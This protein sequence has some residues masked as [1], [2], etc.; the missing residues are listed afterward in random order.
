MYTHK[1]RKK[2]RQLPKREEGKG[3]LFENSWNWFIFSFYSS[4]FCVSSSQSSFLL[5]PVPLFHSPWLGSIVILVCCYADTST[6]FAVAAFFSFPL[7]FRTIGRLFVSFYSKEKM[8]QE[9][10]Y[11][12]IF[13][14]HFLSNRRKVM[15]YLTFKYYNFSWYMWPTKN[16]YRKQR[17][18]EPYRTLI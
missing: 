2:C 15:G 12:A 18:Y 6:P 10:Y 17:T 8:T 9:Y 4:I 16:L 1:E 3:D 13:L 5:S 7:S 11:F 14:F